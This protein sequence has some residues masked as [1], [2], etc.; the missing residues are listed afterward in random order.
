MVKYIRD[1]TKFGGL[2]YESDFNTEP[3]AP[4]KHMAQRIARDWAFDE[5]CRKNIAE[6][7]RRYAY[8]SKH[9]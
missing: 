2:I 9:R 1:N 4:S 7:E 5:K 3:G 6:R 8:E